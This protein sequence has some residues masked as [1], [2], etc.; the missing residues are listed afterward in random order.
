MNYP[1]LWFVKITGLPIQFFYYRKKIYYEDETVQNRQI[2]GKALI[3]SN[4]KSIYDYPLVMYTFFNRAVRVLISESLYAKN[5]LFS[6]F[7]NALGGIKVDRE[8]C[9]MSFIE[10]SIKVLDRDKTLLI[11]P[12]SRLPND[13][14]AALDSLIEFKPSFVYIALES[15]APIIPVYT[16]GKYGKDKKGD[17]TR[18]IIGKPIDV[19]QYYDESKSEKENVN[20]IVEII[21]NKILYLKEMLEKNIGGINE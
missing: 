13:E 14:E 16:N 10:K 19:K 12:E 11:Y 21:K 3:V 20:Q 15:G 18:M 6:W 9:D 4:H 5:G 2:K 17:R 7:L 8:T 1:L